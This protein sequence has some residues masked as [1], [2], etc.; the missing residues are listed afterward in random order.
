MSFVKPILKT[1]PKLP[2]SREI[3]ELW[4]KKQVKIYPCIQPAD[5]TNMTLIFGEIARFVEPIPSLSIAVNDAGPYYKITVKGLKFLTSY[6]NWGRTFLQQSENQVMEFVLDTFTLHTNTG[7]IKV[8]HVE[9]IRPLSNNNTNISNYDHV[10]TP[11]IVNTPIPSN[12]EKLEIRSVCTKWAQEVIQKYISILKTQDRPYAEA[13]FTEIAMLEYPFEELA[14]KVVDKNEVYAVVI[15][16]QK[17]L[18][19]DR[20]WINT[21]LG[22]NRD[23]MLDN[24]K[25]CFLQDEDKGSI[26][27]F[28]L[29]KVQ[30]QTSSDNTMPIYQPTMIP[31]SRSKIR[32]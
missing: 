10:R 3:S 23:Q 21:F 11:T 28:Y 9:K 31:S 20:V 13:L 26:T 12:N 1:R 4:A 14:A 8:L 18:S 16:G 30:F 19:N 15:Q 7:Y 24:V 29:D 6:I 25:D 17:Q 5:V 32:K 27:M 2:S 22:E